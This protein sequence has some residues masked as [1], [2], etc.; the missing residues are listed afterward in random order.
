MQLLSREED[1]WFDRKSSRVHP[2]DLAPTLIAFANAEGGLVAVGLHEGGLDA[3]V[4]AATENALRQTAVDFTVPP[5][6]LVVERLEVTTDQGSGTILVLEVRASDR[7]HATV[8]DEVF[9]RIGDEVRRLTFD[10]RRELEFDKGQSNFEIS[11]ARV[12]HRADLDNELLADVAQR[13]GSSDPDRLLAARGLAAAAPG[14]VT[15]G[16][17]LLFAATPQAE[18]PEAHIRVLR[19]RGVRRGTGRRQ[20]IVEDVRVEGPLASQIDRTRELVE[21]LVPRRRALDRSG[22]FSDVA[23]IPADAW[24]EGIVNAVTHRS[25]SMMGDHVRVEIFDDRMEI[26]S[27]GRF[28]GVVDVQDP[29][30]ISRFARNPRIARV[31]ADL[32][33]GQ[34]LGEGIRRMFEEMRLAGLA[35]PQ[36][37]Q[38]SGSVTLLL[39]ADPVDRDLERRLSSQARVLVRALRDAGRLSTGELVRLTGRSRPVVLRDLDELRQAGVIEWHGRSK[40]DPRAYWQLPR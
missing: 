40:K 5:V 22:R 10:Q 4:D 7:I 9:L 30:R 23:A 3:E 31:L 39:P 25:Y 28:P 14:G 8:R 11:P 21:G 27:P 15:M 16:A 38:T 32:D 20:Q 13:L 2:R 19:Y 26:T 34:E 33:F 1:Q 29:E 35:E 12:L 24:M 6:A 36:Y 17:V 18:L 37:S